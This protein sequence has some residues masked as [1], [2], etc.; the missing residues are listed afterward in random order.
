[1]KEA[2]GGK[3]AGHFAEQKVHLTLRGKYW[4]KG[5]RTNVC[6]YCCSCLAC[7]SRKGPGQR[8][9]TELSPIPVG[10]PF[11]HCGSRYASIARTFD[12]DQYAIVFVNYLTKWPDV[13][14]Y[15]TRKLRQLP[16]CSWKELFKA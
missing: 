6:Q 16:G 8:Q 13:F 14:L 3:F 15:Q 12:G 7:A 1:M 5:M 9:H 11:S 10:G 4:W 2:H